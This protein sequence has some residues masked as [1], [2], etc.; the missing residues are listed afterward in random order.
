[1]LDVYGLLS[2][3]IHYGRTIRDRFVQ[4]VSVHKIGLF[5]ILDIFPGIVAIDGHG[6]SKTI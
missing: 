6:I 1:M 5:L 4:Y 2:N 3:N